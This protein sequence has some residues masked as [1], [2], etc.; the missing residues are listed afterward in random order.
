MTL[1]QQLAALPPE[2]LATRDEVKIAAALNAGR[3]RP[4]HREI[5]NGTILETIGLAAGNTLLDVINTAPDFRHVKPLVEQGRLVVG[6][7][8]VQA[9]VQSLAGTV[10]TQ[11]QAD[12]LCALGNDANP[13]DITELR[14]ALWS[15]DG[16]YLWQ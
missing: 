15:D 12:A 2:L 9:T 10:L 7:A 4:N 16:A 13:I 5:G 14:A 11:A 3:T 1:A 8:L 6:S